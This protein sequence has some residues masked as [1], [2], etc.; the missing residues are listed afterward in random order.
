VWYGGWK[1]KEKKEAKAV[2]GGDIYTPE[3]GA[4]TTAWQM[5]TDNTTPRDRK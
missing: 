3:K 5:L 2:G 1:E 4:R